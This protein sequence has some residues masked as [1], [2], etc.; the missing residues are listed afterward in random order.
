MMIL[1]GNSVPNPKKVF[2]NSKHVIEYAFTIKDRHY[3]QFN[4][5]LNMPYD[6]ALKALV[7][8]KEF[9]M[10]ISRDTLAQ[11]T[12]AFDSVFKK[13]RFT[14]DD[15]IELK[16]LNNLLRERI[17][18][19]KEPDLMYKLAAVIFFDQFENPDTYEFKYGENKIR[20]WKK[21]TDLKTFFL[22]KP[23]RTLI[24]YLD[25]AEEN[26]IMFSQMV[27]A[28]TATYTE[29]LS[30]ILSKTPNTTLQNR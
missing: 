14:M 1:T 17:E 3:F 25:Y 30:T 15:L 20:H 8:Y 5:P 28:R 13:D 4:D 23:L 12:E 2:S 18:L 16:R 22:S 6:R 10:N 11:H 7:Y 9:D 29:A 24:P 21:E 27:E 19:P 26:L